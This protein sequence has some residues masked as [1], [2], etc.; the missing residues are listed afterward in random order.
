[1]RF[2]FIFFAI[3]LS[4]KPLDIPVRAPSA[5][6]INADSGAV[7]FEKKGDVPF[8]PAS[9]TKIATA[10]YILDQ[11][12]ISLSREVTVSEES[13]RLRPQ[14]GASFLP[15]WLENDGSSIGLVEGEVV[16]LET[17][18]HGMLLASGNDASNVLVEAVSGSI[19]RFVEELNHYLR[20]I[21]CLNTQFRNPHGLHCPDHFTTASDMGLIAQRALKIPK[22][23]EIVSKLSYMKPK[24]N[25]QPAQEI[26]Q[27]NPLLKPKSEFYYPKAIGVKT[28]HTSKASY[29]LVAAA[30]QE[31]RTLIAVVSGCTKKDR[32]EDVVRLFEA[33]FAEEKEEKT[34]FDPGQ[35]F[36]RE[37]LGAKNLLRAALGSPLSISY[38]PAEETPYKAQLVWSLPSLPIQKGQK[39]GELQILTPQGLLLQRGDLLAKEEVGRTWLFVLRQL[40]HL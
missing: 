36:S 40:F 33:A 12:K 22:F 19:P 5:V 16:S 3:F 6:L 18:L 15:H 35:I 28:G 25:K 20:A 30:E 1:M 14:K 8:Y 38:Y 17:L 13:L 34:L 24:N 9:I 32:C 4:A 27:T 23:R 31:G 26:Q 37:I 7:L 21:G 10:L 29:T 11:K 39:V 2:L